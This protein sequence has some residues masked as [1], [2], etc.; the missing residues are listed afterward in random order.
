[1]TQATLRDAVR[2]SGVGLHTGADASVEIRPAPTDHGVQFVI[3]GVRVPATGEHVVETARAT[4]LGIGTHMVSTV[5]HVLSAL[6]G[7]EIANAEIAVSGPEIP[8]VDGSA[9]AFADAFAQA[10]I[11]KQSRPTID[12]EPLE[13]F[14][15][16][17]GDRALIVLPG[18][19]LRV[20][21]V[22]DFPP[23][24]G[25]QYFD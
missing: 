1:M 24:V 9:K 23:P 16:R 14:E 5:E 18:D 10:G 11:E 2:F 19:G 6:F 7:M 20:R 22:A 15:M 25:V 13:P 4:V 17:D 12:F 3:D 8:I 21:F